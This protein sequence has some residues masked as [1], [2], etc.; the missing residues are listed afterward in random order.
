MSSAA[1]RQGG[2]KYVNTTFLGDENNTEAN[3]ESKMMK[4]SLI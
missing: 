2:R 4:K 1:K 3:T